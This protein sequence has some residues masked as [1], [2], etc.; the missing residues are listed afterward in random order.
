MNCASNFN[1][2]SRQF[3]LPWNS[4]KAQLAVYRKTLLPAPGACSC[5]FKFAVLVAAFFCCILIARCLEITEHL[6]ICSIYCK[7]WKQLRKNFSRYLSVAYELH[8]R[9][10]S[11]HFQ[12]CT[13]N[14]KNKT[15]NYV[16]DKV[17]LYPKIQSYDYIASKIL[18][19]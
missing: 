18:Y 14:H 13:A 5:E 17:F 7:R 6:D 3:L 2:I 4:R 10:H 12:D 9:N 1:M 19:S 8:D 16:R 15:K 11:I